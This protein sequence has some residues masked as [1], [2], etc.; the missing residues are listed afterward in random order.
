MEG[1]FLLMCLILDFCRIAIDLLR[2]CVR[3]FRPFLL[4]SRWFFVRELRLHLTLLL[5]AFLRYRYLSI[6]FFIPLN[7]DSR[8]SDMPRLFISA[9]LCSTWTIVGKELVYWMC[10]WMRKELSLPHSF[11]FLSGTFMLIVFRF[12]CRTA[13]WLIGGR[14]SIFF[15]GFP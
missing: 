13:L 1:C 15:L 2:V 11:C 8:I 3:I 9:S 5:A 12:S 4:L 14:F 6:L 7:L 10:F